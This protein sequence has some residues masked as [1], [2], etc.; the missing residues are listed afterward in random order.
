ML[1]TMLF[2]IFF[3]YTTT[4]C[5]PSHRSYVHP[6][7]LMLTLILFLTFFNFLLLYYNSLSVRTYFVQIDEHTH[8]IYH[9]PPLFFSSL[10]YILHRDCL[11]FAHVGWHLL[12]LL[13]WVLQKCLPLSSGRWLEAIH[14]EMVR[15]WKWSVFFTFFLCKFPLF[16]SLSL[17]LFSP[18]ITSDTLLFSL[19]VHISPS[20]PPSLSYF[21]FVSLT[22]YFSSSF[23]LPSSFPFFP[24]LSVSPSNLNVLSTY[25]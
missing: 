7:K 22:L 4:E 9:F 17:F 25:L 11:V 10:L 16:L 23:L 1:I 12:I 19:S 14:A 15:G 20:L 21:L 3:H 13:L 24:S 8:I 18:L 6:H 2:F 5:W